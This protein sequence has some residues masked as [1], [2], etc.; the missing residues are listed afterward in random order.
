[1]ISK[2]KKL[3]FRLIPLLF[4]LFLL[5]S[6]E[7]L[8]RVFDPSLDSPLVESVQNDS[9]EAY[10]INRGSLVKYFSSDNVI[11]P[12]LKPSLFKKHKAAKDFRIV[13]LGESSMFGTPY[14]MNA[15][16][17]SILRKQLRHQFPYLEFEVINLGAA[18]VNSNVILDLAKQ[19]VEYR[20]RS[21]C[22][23]HGTQ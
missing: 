9:K 16:I 22:C 19:A 14:Q 1:M 2:S 5:V 20:T 23:L 7:L 21:H 4:F 17:P 11:V 12:E 3:V 15:N 18:A 8:L 13:C 6:V 10:Q